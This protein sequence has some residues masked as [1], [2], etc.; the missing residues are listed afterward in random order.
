MG[1][2]SATIPPMMTYLA[3]WLL[4]TL[5]LLLTAKLTP[6]IRITSFGAALFGALIIG[7]VNMLVWPV[8]VFLTLPLTLITFGLFLFCVN[9]IALKIS[10][11]LSPGFEIVGFFPAVVGSLVLTL[12]GYLVRYVFYSMM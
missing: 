6:G 8:L 10:A 9:G 7:L 5:A 2:R 1:V 12:V 4:A 11:A 3:H